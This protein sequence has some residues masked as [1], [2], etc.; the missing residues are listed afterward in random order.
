MSAAG[1]LRDGEDDLGIGEDG[2]PWATDAELRAERRERI[3]DELTDEERAQV[4]R[5]RRL[6]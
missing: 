6:R 4:V 3:W 1:R 2:H 5:S